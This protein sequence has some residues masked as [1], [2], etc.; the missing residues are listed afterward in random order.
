MGTLESMPLAIHV[1]PIGGKRITRVQ[2]TNT[3]RKSLV[4]S[5]ACQPQVTSEA[6]AVHA[7]ASHSRG[8]VSSPVPER[9][10]TAKSSADDTAFIFLLEPC[11][12]AEVNGQ[13]SNI[14]SE[15]ARIRPEESSHVRD[16]ISNASPD[17]GGLSRD[18]GHH[19]GFSDLSGTGYPNSSDS[20]N[21]FGSDTMDGASPHETSVR[22]GQERDDGAGAISVQ[23]T[24]T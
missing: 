10:S 3:D 6:Q 20:F 16:P 11:H 19:A 18:L 22:S 7:R 9:L 17:D 23:A 5:L 4:G 15:P 13:S 24:A 2:V 21:L 12:G 8:L 1:D 14:V